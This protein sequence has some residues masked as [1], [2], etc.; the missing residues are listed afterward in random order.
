MTSTREE[1]VFHHPY[2]PYD[3]Q[4][5]F[6]SALYSC[7]EDGK[8][9][10]FESPTGTG[11]SLSLICGSL[12]WL[13]DH[14]RRKFEQGLEGD[15]KDDDEP[16]WM[17]EFTK[18]EKKR[19][20]L[21]RKEELEERLE[22]IRIKEK[23]MR[24][25]GRDANNPAKRVKTAAAKAVDEEEDFVL[26][27]YDSDHESKTKTRPT[28]ADYGLSA[29]T[30]ALLEKY[31]MALSST[32]ADQESEME[33][34][35]KVF[36]CSRTHSQLSQFAN[37]LR[38]VKMPPAITP[39]SE[40]PDELLETQEAFK[41]LTLSSRKN[42]CINPKVNKL[43]NASAINE[44]C[45]ELQQPKTAT[46]HKCPFVPSK[47]N[48][49][50]VA[51]FRDHA[52]A[53]IRD[54][55]DLGNLGKRLGVCPYYASRPAI[56]PCEIVT[57][58]YPLLL[59]KSA[60][61]ALGLSLKGHVVIVDE[62][63][64]LMDA[65]TAMYSVSVSLTQIERSRAQLGIY[66]QKFRNRL[67]GKNRVYV[68]QTVRLLDSLLS[69]L[70]SKIAAGGTADT[71]VRPGDL[72]GGKGVD[73]INLYK[74]TRYLQES[75]LARKVDGYIVHSEQQ[76]KEQ[77]LTNKP[78]ALSRSERPE[79]TTPVL[80]HIQSFLLTLMNPSAEGRFFC[81]KLEDGGIGLKY[82]LL[83]PTQHFKEIVEEARAVVLAGG[84]MSPMSDYTQQL[85]PYL[86]TES[87]MTLSCGH[88]I[89]PSS[90]L[91]C[92]VTRTLNGSAFD[93]T[94]EKRNSASMIRELG[95]AIHTFC[96]AIPDG[97][98]VFFPS[99]AYLDECVKQW[100][101]PA[102]ASAKP[103]WESLQS[104]KPVFLESRTVQSRTQTAKISGGYGSGPSQAESLL[105]AYTNAVTTGAGRGALLLAVIGGTLSEG[106]NF[107]DSLGRGVAV[108]GMPFP[109]PHSAEWKAKIKFITEK[110]ASSAD[111][112]SVQQAGK[113][114]AR[115]YYENVCMRAVNQAIG[116]AIRHR[117]DYAAILLLDRRYAG[118]RIRAK[119]P[120]WIKGSLREG[121]GVGETRDVLRT[122][123]KE[124]EKE[125]RT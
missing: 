56:K 1:R 48:E 77:S 95:E 25:R 4:L 14:K 73:Q 71:I 17:I 54:I 104:A 36:F 3:I 122:F 118:E 63:H 62:A 76:Q 116:R 94:F 81:N 84:T 41:H 47:D 7:I 121:G 87:I 19:E 31:G 18:K 5:Q 113:D 34:E 23:K 64:N 58:P 68:T 99:Y 38:R 107:S 85:F 8:I 22:R 124:K 2:T 49:V 100:K 123:F 12:T 92:P 51:D 44:R 16:E 42:L 70:Q 45:L 72:M 32:N 89:P 46:E 111:G 98:V 39:E 21:G 105:T 10:I 90:L 109:N 52:L 101:R 26:D 114:A 75:H 53:D 35:M 69:F 97:V 88:V 66:L 24:E 43:G 9:G 96:L 115:E 20:A 15:P 125:R 60:R 40:G 108:V 106:I 119:L 102:A 29:E 79:A 83:D 120:Q 6:M 103:I 67:K 117:G 61:E 93:F 80:T 91:A 13:R 86:P 82:M 30:Q 59:Q 65:I 11:K 50:A 27:D 55:E 112:V 57:L 33:D 28:T 37:E 110:A 78:N 74:L